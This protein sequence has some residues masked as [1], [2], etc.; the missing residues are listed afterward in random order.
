M[1]SFVRAQIDP[2]DGHRDSCEQRVGQLRLAADER[3]DRAVVIGVGMD[4]QQAGMRIERGADRIDRRLVATFA[5][6]GN[7]L[8]RQHSSYSR[9]REGVLRPAGAGI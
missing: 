3:E 1:R 6:V 9:S 4:V 5:E 7:R 2:L 8:E